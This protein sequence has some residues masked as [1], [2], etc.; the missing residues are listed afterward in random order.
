MKKRI[1]IGSTAAALLLLAVCIWCIPSGYSWVLESNWGISL[2]GQ[3][4]LTEVYEQDSGDSAHGD[5]IRYHVYDCD[6]PDAV[7]EMVD[8]SDEEP[9]TNYFDSL[10]QAAEEWLNEIDVPQEQRPDPSVCIC[11]YDEQEDGSE[12]ILFWNGEAGRLYLV[13]SFL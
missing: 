10:S 6:A 12:I 11:W 3:A 4:H 8:W 5:G 2:P 7:L 13:E 1:F 9:A